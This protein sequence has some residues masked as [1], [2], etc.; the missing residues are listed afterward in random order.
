MM[1]STE[2]S[3]ANDSRPTT[4]TTS[5]T[6]ASGVKKQRPTTSLA[7]AGLPRVTNVDVA[8]YSTWDPRR[9]L[10]NVGK[11]TRRRRQDQDKSLDDLAAS[12]NSN[13][14][15]DADVDDLF[16][17]YESASDD[18]RLNSDFDDDDDDDDGDDDD[19][20]TET[21]SGSRSTSYRSLP[22]RAATDSTPTVGVV[23]RGAAVLQRRKQRLARGGVIDDYVHL[24]AL[25]VSNTG[26]GDEFCR[27]LAHLTALQLLA[28]SNN[29]LVAPWSAMTALRQLSTLDLR[30]NRVRS[31]D[32]AVRHLTALES[33][34][35]DNNVVASVSNYIGGLV[36]LRVLGLANNRLIK[37]PASIGL[38]TGLSSLTLDGN[39]AMTWP[40]PAV[41]ANGAR[42]VLS[43][44]R[45]EL[46]RPAHVHRAPLLLLADGG[47]NGA[48]A[49]AHTLLAGEFRSAPPGNDAG[50][51]LVCASL[52]L[53]ERLFDVR[54]SRREPLWPAAFP[55]LLRAGAVALLCIDASQPAR[56]VCARLRRWLAAL[57]RFA[58]TAAALVVACGVRPAQLCSTVSS[59]ADDDGDGGGGGNDDD[60][61]SP[62]ERLLERVFA[63]F[64]TAVPNLRRVVCGVPDIELAPLDAAPWQT[65]ELDIIGD[66]HWLRERCVA[67][68]DEASAT[69]EPVPERV[70]RL[71][72][73]L[74]GLATTRDP[75]LMSLAELERTAA[76]C[77]VLGRG[78]VDAALAHMQQRGTVLYWP[79]PHPTCDALLLR[80]E[81]LVETYAMLL[82]QR[83][84]LLPFDDALHDAWSHLAPQLARRA[85]V[86]LHHYDLVYALPASAVR[87][88]DN[89]AL[90][91]NDDKRDAD[92]NSNTVGAAA[93]DDDEYRS[94]ESS[95]DADE[96]HDDDN[97][98]NNNNRNDIDIELVPLSS[99]S[100]AKVDRTTLHANSLGFQSGSI[101]LLPPLLEQLSNTLQSDQRRWSECFANI[102]RVAHHRSYCE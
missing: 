1:V 88:L 50:T 20:N 97:N 61:T 59:S 14:V 52:S 53:D 54:H 21:D 77:D 4:T 25:D 36:D 22:I 75:P 48:S 95:Q 92:N 47:G 24:T 79:A 7:R 93:N 19:D 56:V 84:V 99:S 38:L 9:K 100:G 44:A 2:F 49:L 74:C 83:R 13:G 55:L 68:A 27:V 71:E 17:E 90:A 64:A 18:N 23:A 16:G 5:T 96:N 40:P 34:R 32:D 91:D 70:A 45:R 8:K 46:E 11:I 62:I 101:L 43:V 30:R 39:N 15:A 81:W 6:Q 57:T 58:P 63:R 51:P 10:S 12:T 60:G 87:L 78:D 31:I 94:Y 66:A 67:A 85:L 98:N 65:A 41:I 28:A 102:V 37:L 26:V 33:L 29:A 73:I 82:D 86:W 72:S 3:R 76:L 35:L 69:L 89:D 42:A 80:P